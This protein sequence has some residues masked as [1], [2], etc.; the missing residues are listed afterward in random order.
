MVK[1]ISIEAALASMEEIHQ[2]VDPSD[3]FESL[4]YHDI[5]EINNILEEVKSTDLKKE[6]LG[7]LNLY[8]ESYETV[9]FDYKM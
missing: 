9:G 2:K 6:V 5:I 7:L 1:F 8:F 4:L 3:E